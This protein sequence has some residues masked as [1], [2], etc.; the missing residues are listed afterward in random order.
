[1]LIGTTRLPWEADQ[2]LLIQAYQKMIYIPRPDYG[3]L[4]RL[5]ADQL[6]QYASLSR[7][8]NTSSLARLSDGFTVGAVLGA[9]KD[10]RRTNLSENI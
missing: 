7:Q 1:M 10:V 9:M 5:W 4:S 3:T 8:F 2:K 6:F